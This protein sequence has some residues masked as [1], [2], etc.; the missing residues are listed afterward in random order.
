MIT[1]IYDC[2][3]FSKKVILPDD[4]LIVAIEVSIL[5][6]DE[7]VTFSFDDKTSSTFDS[8]NSRNLSFFDSAYTLE[9]ED[10]ILKWLNFTPPK[11]CISAAYCRRDMYIDWSRWY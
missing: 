3:N 8:S 1:S 9:T 5:S 4:K 11:N 6:G 7:V 10:D 2:N